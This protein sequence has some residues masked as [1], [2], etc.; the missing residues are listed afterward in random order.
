MCDKMRR[1][2][3]ALFL[4]F[5]VVCTATPSHSQT[6]SPYAE[7]HFSPAENLEK[8]D[9]AEL[10]RAKRSIDF[11]AYILTDVAVVDAL[12][13]AADRGVKV[14]I[15]RDGNLEAHGGGIVE[16]AVDRLAASKALIRY[17][18]DAA[19]LMHLKAYCVDGATLRTGSANFSAS[20]LKRQDNDLV[21]MRGPLVCAAFNRNFERMFAQ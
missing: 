4:A 13:A 9:V 5:A 17:K 2:A 10:A 8:I 3:R 1:Y 14:R 19:P 20:G 16:A 15:Y 18:S 7:H 6:A 12:T 11:S 21:I